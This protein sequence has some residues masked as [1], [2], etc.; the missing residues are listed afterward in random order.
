V[1][2][3]DALVVRVQPNGRRDETFVIPPAL[4]DGLAVVE[5]EVV[6][7]EIERIQLGS[8]MLRTGRDGRFLGIRVD[9][10]GRQSV[11]KLDANLLPTP[12]FESPSL[13]ELPSITSYPE[14]WDPQS[15]RV[16][17]IEL[18]SFDRS[19]LRAAVE[20]PDGRVL[21]GGT[22]TQLD[23]LPNTDLIARLDTNGAV[24]A[25]F[26]L[27]TFRTTPDRLERASVLALAVD[28]LQR[29]YVAG[30]FNLLNGQ[31]ARG[32]ARLLPDGSVDAEFESPIESVAYPIET[33]ASLFLQGDT[34]WVGGTFRALDETFPRPLWKL[35]TVT[36]PRL[37]APALAG[38]V[39]TVQARLATGRSYR[40]QRTQ[41]F[42]TWTDLATLA[43]N[44][45]TVTLQD[46]AVPSTHA[47]YRLISP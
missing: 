2:E 16:L 25:S 30:S 47:G 46:S 36:G 17:Q 44:G 26:R 18:T 13:R 45:S 31:P 4:T 34:L 27:P 12:N 38:G 10:A 8:M 11:L 9:H 5:R 3:G 22:F 39:F 42:T 6:T 1:A 37:Q 28:G 7:R 33:E 29:I 35:S 32:L 21:V 14:V 15:G 23:G 24:D 40:F 20:L 19:D 43:G 41:D